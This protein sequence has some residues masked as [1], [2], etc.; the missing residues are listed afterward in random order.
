MLASFEIKKE[1]H[2][3]SEHLQFL[4]FSYFYVKCVC[5]RAM[6]VVYPV[7]NCIEKLLTQ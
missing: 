5:A 7:G 1:I 4:D 2:R 3:I 6:G